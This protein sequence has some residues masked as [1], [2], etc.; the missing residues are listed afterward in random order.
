[1]DL[2]SFGSTRRSS[3]TAAIIMLAVMTLTACNHQSNSSDD[4][5]DLRSTDNYCSSGPDKKNGDVCEFNVNLNY[6]NGTQDT[7]VANSYTIEYGLKNNTARPPDFPNEIAS[8]K[9]QWTSNDDQIFGYLETAHFKLQENQTPTSLSVSSLLTSESNNCMAVFNKNFDAEY[10]S[11]LKG[12][13]LYKLKKAQIKILKTRPIHLTLIPFESRDCTKPSKGFDGTRALAV[14]ISAPRHPENIVYDCDFTTNFGPSDLYSSLEYTGN[15]T[16]CSI[17][18]EKKS[19]VYIAPVGQTPA[20]V[21]YRGSL[22]D[23][24]ENLN[25]DSKPN[26]TIRIGEGVDVS[27]G[28]STGFARM[29]IQLD[30]SGVTAET[31]WS[32]VDDINDKG[33]DAASFTDGCVFSDVSFY[34]KYTSKPILVTGFGRIN[35]DQVLKRYGRCKNNDKLYLDSNKECQNNASAGPWEQARWGVDVQLLNLSSAHSSSEPAID[36][37]DIT[38]AWPAYRGIGAVTLNTASM[39]FPPPHP[40]NDNNTKV[41]MFNVKQAGAWVDQA[42]GPEVMGKDSKVSFSYIHSGDDAVKISAPGVTYDQSTVLHGSAGGVVNIGS[43][44][45]NRTVTGSS[46]KGLYIHRITNKQVCDPGTPGCEPYGFDATSGVITSRTCPRKSYGSQT[47]MAS[48]KDVTIDSVYIPSLTGK[49]N[50]QE[51]PNSINRLFSLGIQQD[52]FCEFNETG[53]LQAIDPPTDFEFGDF[54]FTNFNIFV[55]PLNES[56][57]YSESSKPGSNSSVPTFTWEPIRF[58]TPAADAN[59]GDRCSMT[60]SGDKTVWPGAVKVYNLTVDPSFFY[61]ACA[62]QNPLDASGCWNSKG[63]GT[64]TGPTA[65]STINNIL[66]SSTDINGTSELGAQASPFN[67]KVVNPYTTPPPPPPP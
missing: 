19:W 39:P 25:H 66:Y 54:T 50:S 46:I 15:S 17:K 35:G 24:V 28:L 13:S 62:Q 49:P 67:N 64:T 60:G 8:V 65:N 45:Y 44:G 34:S 48:L 43:Y 58:C 3:A 33:F 6:Q 63:V 21:E 11:T 37:S 23:T 31:C 36:V 30:P 12:T 5:D 42:D 2:L 47:T 56:Y 4:S 27:R 18:D 10:I 55:N 20:Y 26:L 7:P 16:I 57:L 1:M 59:D 61:Y 41:N 40:I 22:Y 9:S 38:V 53:E 14:W 52:I 32:I 29:T 51:G